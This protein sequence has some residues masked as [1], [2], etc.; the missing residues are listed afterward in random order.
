M[1]QFVYRC[2]YLFAKNKLNQFIQYSKFN[3]EDHIPSLVKLEFQKTLEMKKPFQ[4]E[5]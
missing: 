4:V 1:R 5:I 2:Y 3:E